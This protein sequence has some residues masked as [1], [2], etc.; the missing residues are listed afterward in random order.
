MV[1]LLDI[2][3]AQEHFVCGELQSK[4]TEREQRIAVRSDPAALDQLDPDALRSPS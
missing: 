1:E 4:E 2:E 3:S